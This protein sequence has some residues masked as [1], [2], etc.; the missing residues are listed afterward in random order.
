[1]NRGCALSRNLPDGVWTRVV[2][3]VVKDK[4]SDLEKVEVK[5]GVKLSY[6][7]FLGQ[8][9]LLRELQKR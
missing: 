1:M 8:H 6:D 2:F 4:A 7:D 3:E 9:Q 5:N